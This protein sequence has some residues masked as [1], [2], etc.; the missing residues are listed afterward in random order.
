M[1]EVAQ[2]VKRVQKSGCLWTAVFYG[3]NFLYCPVLRNVLLFL[4]LVIAARSVAISAPLN[5]DSTVFL[6]GDDLGTVQDFMVVKFANK[7]LGD[8]I[9]RVVDE[10]GQVMKEYIDASVKPG[11]HQA[12]V[13]VKSLEPGPYSITL[14]HRQHRKQSKF[15][16]K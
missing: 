12:F 3:L 6:I 14:I 16:K 1:K 11:F 5:N 7:E 13:D 4:L 9:I 15:V 8:I 10:E 2:T